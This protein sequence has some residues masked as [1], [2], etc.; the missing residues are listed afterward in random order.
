[1][2]KHPESENQQK[3]DFSGETFNTKPT[4]NL[5]FYHAWKMLEIGTVEQETNM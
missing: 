5:N 4:L 1:L 3:K 2:P